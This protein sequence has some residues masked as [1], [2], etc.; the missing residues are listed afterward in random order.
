M[1]GELSSDLRRHALLPGMDLAN[2][3]QQF[4]ARRALEQVS[5]G[6]RPQRA[7][8]VDVA[9]ERCQHHDARRREFRADRDEGVDPTQV[10]KTEVHECDI[11]PVLAKTLNPIFA[12]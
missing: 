9:V 5:I 12:G 11:G 4:L 3:L 6:A 2:R 1:L 10:W 8:Y 7:L